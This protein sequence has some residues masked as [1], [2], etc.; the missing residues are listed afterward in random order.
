MIQIFPGKSGRVIFLLL[1]SSNFWPSLVKI[2]HAV[3]EISAWQTDGLTNRGSSSTE[4]E[5]CQGGWGHLLNFSLSTF[6]MFKS[7]NEMSEI[8]ELFEIVNFYLNM[9]YQVDPTDQTQENGQKPLF[10]LFGSFKN[11]FFWFLNDP[12]W[13]GNIAES[14]KTF[15]TITIC[16]IKSIQQ[17]K[18][19]KMAKNLFFG[20]LDHSKKY[21]SDLWMIVMNW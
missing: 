12:A 3:T 20:S 15:S 8:R 4:V 19:Q 17:T 11:A 5:N 13:P 1:L 2:Q 14:W 21:F 18:L 7:L 10:W 6:K 16:N 9:Q